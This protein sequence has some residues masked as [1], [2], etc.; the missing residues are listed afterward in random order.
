MSGYPSTA[1]TTASV[2][3]IRNGKLYIAHVGDSTIVMGM[4]NNPDQD[5]VEAASITQVIMKRHLVVH[6]LIY[7]T[8]WNAI[9]YY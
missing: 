1:G 2:C 5:Y 3:F 9:R 6:T 8:Q 7:H 4:K